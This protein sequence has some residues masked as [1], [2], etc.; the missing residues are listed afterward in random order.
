MATMINRRKLRHI[1]PEVTRTLKQPLSLRPKLGRNLEHE[2]EVEDNLHQVDLEGQLLE[3]PT[4]M[5]IPGEE[6]VIRQSVSPDDDG[7]DV[8]P[9]PLEDNAGK[10]EQVDP[11]PP[12]RRRPI[13]RPA[14]P[15]PLPPVV[16]A[17][18]SP[19]PV[20]LEFPVIPS[21]LRFKPPK[22]PEKL[23]PQKTIPDDRFRRVVYI[24]GLLKKKKAPTVPRWKNNAATYKEA[25]GKA[26]ERAVSGQIRGYIQKNYNENVSSKTL[27]NR[28]QTWSG[29]RN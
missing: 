4:P 28:L 7:A 20:A 17:A 3:K 24:I 15:P 18:A 11:I 23:Y 8:D 12:P 13:P 27:R 21:P 22:D 14:Q 10:D 25:H 2:L 16:V 9:P 19:T 5:R 29:L 26:L 1:D 6:E